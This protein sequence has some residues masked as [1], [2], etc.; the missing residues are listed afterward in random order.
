MQ[1][2]TPASENAGLRSGR[3]VSENLKRGKWG[4]R[5]GKQMQKP[6]HIT[7]TM[8]GCLGWISGAS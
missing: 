7:N 1:L 2:F 8:F 5:S 6:P 3:Y 4:T